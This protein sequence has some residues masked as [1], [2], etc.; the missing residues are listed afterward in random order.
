M[1]GCDWRAGDTGGDGQDFLAID[2]ERIHALTGPIGIE[3]AEPGDVLEVDVL[4][5][6]HKGGV[7]ERYQWARLSG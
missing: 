4:E 6:Q 5:V 7:D 2:R 3:G 1:S